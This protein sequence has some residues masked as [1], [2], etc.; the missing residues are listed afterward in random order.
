[1]KS[2]VQSATRIRELDLLRAV[3][4]VA[5][6]TCHLPEYLLGIPG[7]PDLW[8][9]RPYAAV[10]GLGLFTFVSGYAIDVSQERTAYRQSVVE[11][12]RCRIGRIFP[13]YIP[14]VLCFIVLFHC[15]GVW[16]YQ[17]FNPIVATTIIQ[18]LG[19]Q[20]LLSPLYQPMLTLWFVGAILMYY[21][22]YF[23]LTRLADRA[24][25]LTVL[26]AAVFVVAV[27]VRLTCGLI[28]VQFLLY[29][30]PF[31]AGVL[32]H[33]FRLLADG[34]FNV[35]AAAIAALLALAAGTA[36]NICQVRL[37]VEA[38]SRELRLIDVAPSLAFANVLML[39]SVAAALWLARALTPRM[40]GHAVR[41]TT[42]LAALSYP[43]YLFHR[44]CLA[45]AAAGLRRLGIVQPIAENL[46]IFCIGL[47]AA[48]LVAAFAYGIERR[49]TN[50]CEGRFAARAACQ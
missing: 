2:Q 15:V 29:W 46:G 3:A 16:Q 20:V 28:G 18:L 8:A 22:I 5:I 12:A 19:A 24:A 14:A 38:D 9:V 1:M 23:V 27:V 49:V 45:V 36:A 26:G 31:L 10:F 43:M 40:S 47:P 50:Y 33:R 25:I 7:L 17:P 30:F 44:P 41:A 48:I 37:F 39:S 32:C 11:F 21:G 35:A 4:I 34:R 42:Y 6:V 13:L